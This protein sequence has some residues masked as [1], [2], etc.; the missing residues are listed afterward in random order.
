MEPY[1]L[2]FRWGS[3]YVWGWCYLREDYRLFKLNR[4]EEVR[5]TGEKFDKRR[6]PAPDLSDERIFPGGIQVKVLFERECK[7][8]L[9][10]DF[11]PKC[12]KE[13]EDGK[14]LFQADYTDE[15]NLFAWVMAFGDK[16]E[17]LEPAGIRSKI[18]ESVKKM[19]RKYIT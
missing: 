12:F 10:E 13:L 1:Y 15:E 11:G 9:V 17:V 8:R 18:R 6:T 2:V 19:A 5:L 3:W 4:M 16:A 14:L 7:W